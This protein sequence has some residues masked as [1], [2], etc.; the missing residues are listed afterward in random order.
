MLEDYPSGWLSSIYSP[1]ISPAADKVQVHRQPESCPADRSADF[2]QR[3]GASGQ[4]RFD[5]AVLDFEA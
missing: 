4:G 3:A 2:A 5:D 1:G